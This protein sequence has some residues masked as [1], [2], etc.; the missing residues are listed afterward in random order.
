MISRRRSAATSPSTLPAK[1]QRNSAGPHS[2]DVTGDVIETYGRNHK[3]ETTMTSAT[4]AMSIKLEATTGIEFKCGG[5]SIVLTPAAI[6]IVGGPIVNVNSGSGPP[7]GPV[8][9]TASAPV[10]PDAPTDADT[11]KPGKDTT[12]SGGEET[13]E[14][15]IPED[16][17]GH[18]IEADLERQETSWIEIELVDESGKPIPYE[19]YEITAPDGKTLIRGTLDRNGQ[20]RRIVPNVGTCQISFP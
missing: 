2:V 13:V 14:G 5:S 8:T 7:V 4:K 17:A 15:E 12:Y 1:S 19:P 6:F 10:A 9:A 3:N 18:E 16:I 11:V 20:A